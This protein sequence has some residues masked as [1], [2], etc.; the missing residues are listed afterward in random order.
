[1]VAKLWGVIIRNRDRNFIIS[2]IELDLGT[3]HYTILAQ[4]EPIAIFRKFLIQFV[5]NRLKNMIL[6]EIESLASIVITENVFIHNNKYYRQIK[7]T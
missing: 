3:F 5:H 7:G 6:I 4:E 1:M 2:D